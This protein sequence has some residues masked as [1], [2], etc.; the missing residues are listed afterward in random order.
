MWT[1]LGMA[2][3]VL[4]AAALALAVPA[5]VLSPGSAH[6]F[7]LLGA[8]GL[9][10]YG[11]AG[12][13]LLRAFIYVT[14]R[15]PALR[16]AA[17]HSQ[18][19]L[20]PLY[21]VVTAYRQETS[22]TRRVF[23]A[24]LDEA[25]SCGC[26]MTVVAAVTDPAERV[27]LETVFRASAPHGVSL[28][29]M[30]QDGTGK[31]SALAEGLRA[32]SRRMPP[33]DAVVLLMD[34][35]TLLPPGAL[36]ASL[37]FFNVFPA[38]GAVTT[39]LRAEVTGSPW[40]ADWYDLR[41]AQRHLLMSSISLSDRLLVLTGRC[42]L[43]RASRATRPDFIAAIEDDRLRHWRYGSLRF[44]T[45]DDKSTWYWLLKHRH[46]MLY[47]PDVRV[48]SLE[49]MPRRRFLADSAQ[50]MR[51]WYGNMLRN[52]GRALRLGPRRVRPFVWWCLLD[53]RV[54]MWTSLAGPAFVLTAALF[55]TAALLPAYLLWV[56]VSRLVFAIGLG[57][58][59]G[60]FTP[61]WPLLLYYNQVVGAVLKVVAGFNLDRQEW[62]RQKVTFPSMPRRAGLWGIY[63][64]LLASALFLYVTSAT[65]ASLDPPNWL[66]VSGAFAGLEHFLAEWAVDAAWAG[67][68]PP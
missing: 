15:F 32:I 13:H 51:R 56:M 36:A 25:R 63:I 6:F 40:A 29:T 22:V 49:D 4:V 35:D 65:T 43:F 38:I 17:R 62:G 18:A 55:A 37:P 20:P 24:L 5:E 50:R 44:L 68:T 31:R 34:G 61:R 39:D 19:P 57:A 8:I 16:E 41:Y 46:A 1:W 59:R 3:Y 28:V 47:L 23:A 66:L 9:W 11:W 14:W 33:D 58:I 45:G 27:L 60:R 42:S 10:R 48:V 30:E 26:G 21:V 12:V 52:N 54:S 7:A 2:V 67:E 53:Q 64:T